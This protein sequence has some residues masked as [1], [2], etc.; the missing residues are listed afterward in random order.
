MKPRTILTVVLF[1]VTA[2][3]GGYYWFASRDRQIDEAPKLRADY[4]IPAGSLTTL[5]VS[6]KVNGQ[7]QADV[8]DAF[9]KRQDRE[10][11]QRYLADLKNAVLEGKGAFYLGVFKAFFPE[12]GVSREE[13]DAYMA[14][15]PNLSTPE[16]RAV[17]GG[18]RNLQRQRSMPLAFSAPTMTGDE[19]DIKDLRGK[20]VLVDFWDTGCSAC[21]KSMPLIEAAYKKYRSDGFEVVSVVSKDSLGRLDL[22]DIERIER[23]VGASWRYR[24]NGTDR[25]DT[26]AATFA[27]PGKPQYMLLDRQGRLIAE[28]GEVDLGRNLDA[29]LQKHL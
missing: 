18:W 7:V 14:S 12:F 4:A 19:F 5:P 20:V 21:V 22:K 2:S 26:I 27:F 29:L 1:A 10:P 24:I 11:A 3:A 28:T 25:W 13:R 23:Q 9:E 15:F 8:T 6:D 16:L 17:V